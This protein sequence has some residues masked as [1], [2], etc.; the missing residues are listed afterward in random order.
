MAK[1]KY[2]Y[3]KQF[4]KNDVLLPNTWLVVRIDGRGFHKFSDQHKF[5]KPNDQDALNLMNKCA[6]SVMNDIHDIVLAYGQSDEYSFVLKKDC[7][8]YGRRETKIVSTIVSLFTSNYVF[9][10]KNYFPQKEL[11]YPPSFD[12]RAVLYPADNN[13]RDYLSWRQVDCHINNLY[14][15]CFWALVI[16]GKTESEAE[17]ALRGTIS[18]EK[19]ELLFSQFKINYNNL[20]EMF[21]KGSVIIRKEVDVKTT[22]ENGM[23]VT[24]KKKVALILHDDIIGDKFWK[25]NPTLGVI[26]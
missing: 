10:W 7:A 19:N 8:L 20:P 22:C 6:V 18:S 25:E 17:N 9:Y 3:V 4:E 2:E 14:N 15:T 24:R 23:E 5:K 21:R 13:F 26:I 16:S 11:L 12:G 1:S